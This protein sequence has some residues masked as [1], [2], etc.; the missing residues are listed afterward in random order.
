LREDRLLEVLGQ[1]G[2]F[3]YRY[4]I[5][6]RGRERAARLF[7][8]SG[9]VGPAPVSLAAYTALLEWQLAQMPL[10]S[11]EQVRA[12]LA[13]LVLPPQTEDLAGLAVSSGRSLMLSGPPGNGKTSLGRL[14]HDAQRGDLWVP[15][16]VGIDST[17]IRV[18]DPQVHEAVP[19]EAEQ[20]W[21]L[22]RRWV[23]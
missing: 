1:A 15:H 11:P 6:Q 23:R 21:Q 14:L 13:G 16:C 10:V 20:S 18:F 4:G 5:T 12:A 2:P 22:D 3:G 8:V 19:V 17:I 7:E 9:Y